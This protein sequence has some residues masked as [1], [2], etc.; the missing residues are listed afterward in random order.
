MSICILG[1]DMRNRLNS[2][3]VSHVGDIETTTEQKGTV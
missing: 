3:G 1:V 2:K